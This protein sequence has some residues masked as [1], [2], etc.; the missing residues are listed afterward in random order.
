MQDHR[1]A[2]A[3]RSISR[4][5][6]QDRRISF[7]PRAGPILDWKIFRPRCKVVVGV[8]GRNRS[9]P[10]DLRTGGKAIEATTIPTSAPPALLSRSNGVNGSGPSAN[11]ARFVFL[12]SAGPIRNND[13]TYGYFPYGV[14]ARSDVSAR[15]NPRSGKRVHANHDQG[16]SLCHVK[17]Q[18]GDRGGISRGN[19]KVH[20]ALSLSFPCG[21]LFPPALHR[22]C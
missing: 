4:M 17:C 7:R 14:H 9:D 8:C 1:L 5:S 18:R 20:A 21:L 19:R 3:K 16:F 11:L 22:V 6:R 2:K 12:Q 10:R 13:G 15:P